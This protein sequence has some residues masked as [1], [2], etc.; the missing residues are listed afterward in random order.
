MKIILFGGGEVLL[1]FCRYLLKKEKF[2][3]VDLITS[4]RH[5]EEIFSNKKFFEECKKIES[6]DF[7]NKFKFFVKSNLDDEEVNKL[8]S[9]SDLAIS[10]GSA[11]IF[12]KK[13]IKKFKYLWSW[14]HSRK[15]TK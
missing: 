6:E 8:Y 12:K 7:F 15:F 11:W 13:H 10:I 4:K 3:K 1:D 2:T 9:S 5:S 14:R